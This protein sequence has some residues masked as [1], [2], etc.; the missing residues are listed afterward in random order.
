MNRW[1]KTF[2][3]L[4]LA[5][6][7]LAGSGCTL[8]SYESAEEQQRR[9]EDAQE[10]NS[11]LAT[12]EAQAMLGNALVYYQEL[13]NTAGSVL[14]TYRAEVP[15]FDETGDRK[16]V[17]GR[18]NEF[19]QTQDAAYREDCQA[20]FNMVKDYYGSGWDGVQ[21]TETPFHTT[22][23]YQML[24]APEEYLTM[25]CTYTS[26][27]DGK[28]K[29][30]YQTGEVFL[31]DTGWEL[32]LAEVFGSKFDAA[33]TKIQA[34]V[35][36]WGVAQGILAEGVGV[37]FTPEQITESFGITTS[38]LRLYIDGFVLSANDP[39]SHIVPLPLEDYAA[40]IPEIEGG[41]EPEQPAQTPETP[42][43]PSVVPVV[44]TVPETPASPSEGTQTPA[45]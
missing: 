25:E 9:Q 11:S 42:A 18:I 3:V 23:S 16:Q 31:L 7:L 20:Y 41:A 43:D 24:E 8:F 28:T 44:P 29:D 21:L 6:C 14:A 26:C 12:V 1:I 35:T 22:V 45:N 19:Y 39:Y 40:L 4:G 15:Q 32:S 17:F 13:I 36:A 27:D 33:K 5:A 37:S 34:D 30:V 10:L 2:S 38:G